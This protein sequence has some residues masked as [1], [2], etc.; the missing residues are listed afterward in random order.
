MWSTMKVCLCKKNLNFKC[1]IVHLV[2]RNWQMCSIGRRTRHLLKSGSQDS[3]VCVFAHFLKTL[4]ATLVFWLEL[5]SLLEENFCGPPGFSWECCD[6]KW[7]KWRV[8]ARIVL[9]WEVDVWWL[10]F[11]LCFTS[12]YSSTLSK[13]LSSAATESASIETSLYPVS[14]C[15]DISLITKKRKNEKKKER[16]NS[17]KN[18]NN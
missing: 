13:G 5:D 16:M 9:D 1:Q 3:C 6:V 4:I 10:S 8:D 18:R 12:Y 7:M 17:Y 15:A 11:S 2:Q 14:H